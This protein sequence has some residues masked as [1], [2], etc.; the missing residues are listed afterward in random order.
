MALVLL[1]NYMYAVAHNQIIL[2]RGEG[3]KRPMGGESMGGERGGGGSR[4]SWEGGGGREVK[5]DQETHGRGEGG[6]VE[7][8]GGRVLF[9]D[10]TFRFI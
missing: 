6:R 1:D 7:G 10:I 3:I 5:G 2:E 4:D 9:G 8:G